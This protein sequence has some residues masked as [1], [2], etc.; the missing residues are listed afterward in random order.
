MALSV[1]DDK[2]VMPVDTMVDDALGD[3]ASMGLQDC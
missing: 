2:A 1:F 3:A